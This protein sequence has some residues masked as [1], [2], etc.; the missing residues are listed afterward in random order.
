MKTLLTILLAATVAFA[1]NV[2]ARDK[3]APAPQPVFTPKSGAGDEYPDTMSGAPS[4]APNST[5][6]AAFQA[7][8]DVDFVRFDFTQSGTW[9]IQTTGSMDTV[10]AVYTSDGTNVAANDDSNPQAGNLNFKMILRVTAP[11]TYYVGIGTF[12][13]TGPYTIVSSFST[14]APPDD[15]GDT[16][17]SA[18]A[19]APNATIQ[20][21]LDYTNDQDWFRV[22]FPSSGAWRVST[23]GNTD[24]TGTIFAADGATQVATNDDID[25]N[26]LNFSMI[27]TIPAAGTYFLR[28]TGYAGAIGPY[29]LNSSFSSDTLASVYTDLWWNPNESGWGINLNQQAN[30]IFA[31]LFT[32]DATGRDYWLVA[33]GMQQQP[34]GSFSGTL[35]QTTGPSFSASPY[36]TSLFGFNSVGTMSVRFPDANSGVLTYTVNGVSVTKN[37]QRQRF[38]I[39]PTCVLTTSSRDTATNYQDLWWNPQEAGWGIN[40]TQQ[41]DIIFAT[42]FTYDTDQKPMWLVAS[43]LHRQSDGSF[44]GD[45]YRTRGPAFNSQ[46]FNPSNV[47]LTTVGTMTLRFPTGSNGTLVYT[48]NGTQ[49]QK[50]ITRQVFGS[51]QTL[52]N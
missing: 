49:V 28:V 30:I 7:P 23:S 1:A 39:A 15:F 50:A 31:T 20:G 8:D 40:L 9:T 48:M 33:S 17:A 24:T 37:I 3:Y 27:V 35:Y 42:L 2:E 12:S 47:T 51:S 25:Q 22:S 16:S 52:C 46:P 4:L 11:V 44:T 36:N 34:D 38:S 13:G 41:S 21:N 19:M 43:G 45:L 6:S 32:Y 14:T 5:T 29:T 10:G 26:N 18:S